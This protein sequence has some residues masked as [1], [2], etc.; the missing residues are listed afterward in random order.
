MIQMYLK[1]DY[2]SLLDTGVMNQCHFPKRMYY[3]CPP[4]NT[5]SMECWQNS[6]VRIS[7]AQQANAIKLEIS[8]KY[9]IQYILGENQGNPIR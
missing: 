3:G 8:S 9:I 4:L 7:G 6:L 5:F 1:F 2:N